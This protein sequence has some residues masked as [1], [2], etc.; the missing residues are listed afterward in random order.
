VDFRL[1]ASVLHRFKWIVA[2]GFLLACAVAFLSFA[3][4]GP[5]GVKY[6]QNETW[7]STA[8]VLVTSAVQDPVQLAVTYAALATSD[9]VTKAAIA[10]HRIR[11]TLA[12][13]FGYT[14]RAST[15][16]PTVSVSAT[17]ATPATS[18]TLANDSIPALK[19]AVARQ[20]ADAGVPASKQAQLQV[21]NRAVPAEAL[22]ATPRSKTP[23]VVAFVL[24]MAATLGLVL[25]LE[26]L[27]P[28]VAVVSGEF[29]QARTSGEAPR[30]RQQA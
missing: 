2:L 14:N 9:E 29:V 22:V 6:R 17:A 23:P 25:V 3:T 27:R 28:R 15:A 4:V 13:D 12:A 19:A 16:L 11:G 26:N 1:F 5:H 21:L 8:R 7:M 24:V 30:I 20:Q 18:A 10:K